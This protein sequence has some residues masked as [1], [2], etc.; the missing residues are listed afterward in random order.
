MRCVRAAATSK[1][2]LPISH[3]TRIVV[4]PFDSPPPDYPCRERLSRAARTERP[5]NRRGP[6]MGALRHARPQGS[7][8]DCRCRN[9]ST[10]ADTWPPVIYISPIDW[11]F[12]LRRLINLRGSVCLY[13]ICLRRG[14]TG[15]TFRQLSGRSGAI[16]RFHVGSPDYPRPRY[17]RYRA[18]VGRYQDRQKCDSAEGYG[19]M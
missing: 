13:H 9:R 11:S 12:S 3:R 14:C 18:E 19:R 8:K 1:Q 6:D 17:R 15:S 2:R 4:S 7:R 10:R 16:Y 5:K